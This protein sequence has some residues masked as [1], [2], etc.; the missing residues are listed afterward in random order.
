MRRRH[1]VDRV[2]ADQ[3]L[4]IKH[5]AVV[6]VLG[7]GRGPQQPLRFC[8]LGRELVPARAGKQPLV[9]LIGELGV[10]DRDLALQ[11]GQ[12]FFFGRVVRSRDLF[13]ELL[14]DRAVDAADEKAGDA[15]DMGGIAAL[16]DVFFEAGEIG[17]GDLDVDLLREQQRDVDADAF[18]DQVLD[19]GQAFGRRRHLDHQ[20][21]AVDVLPEP[22]GFG[23]RALGIHR[24]IGRHFQT[25]K[26][27][28][29]FELVVDRAQHVGGMLDVLD[30]KML[31]QFGNRTVALFQRLADRGVIFVRTADRLLEDRRVRRDALDA[32]GIDQLFQVALGDEAAGEKIQ[33]DCLAVVFECFDGIHDACFCRSGRFFGVWARGGGKLIW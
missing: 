17:L 30:R 32:V 24:Q 3:L 22:L 26:A 20:V 19:R 10:G 25:D 28:M 33:P 11:R 21:L 15:R 12:P 4:D 9:F 6:L 7:A 29:P 5:V 31:E 13:V 23:D 14:V 1:G 18:A 27:V 8:T 16:G 2:G